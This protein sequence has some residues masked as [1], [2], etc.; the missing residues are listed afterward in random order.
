MKR[1]LPMAIAAAA[2]LLLAGAALAQSPVQAPTDPLQDQAR[3]DV[4]RMDR[5]GD[6][7]ISRGEYDDAAAAAFAAFD[8]DRD[9]RVEADELEPDADTRPLLG[10]SAQAG[11]GRFRQLDRNDNDELSADEQERS[12]ERQFEARDADDDGFLDL[13]ELRD[14]RDPQPQPTAITP[15]PGT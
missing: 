9:Y 1:R 3:Q 13:D 12:I 7:R 15:P 6:G 4:Q 11:T 2:G 5:D 14:A 10:E 8:T